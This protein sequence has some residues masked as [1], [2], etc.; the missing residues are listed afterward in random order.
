V[1]EAID[2]GASA[3]AEATREHMSLLVAK[4]DRLEVAIAEAFDAILP[5][6]ERGHWTPGEALAW[7]E[8]A[9]RLRISGASHRCAGAL[10]VSTNTLLEWGKALPGSP[11]SLTGRFPVLHQPTPARGVPCVY[12]LL[13]TDSACLYIGTSLYVRRR[14]KVHWQG[15][16]I[17]ATSWQVIVAGSPAEAL[18]LEGDLIFQHQPPYNEQGRSARRR[19]RVT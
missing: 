5:A 4:R 7:W 11:S 10:G 17:P 16:R 18:Q 3:S 6:I 2:H 15:G 14:L 19:T 9:R 1:S 13:D 12:L 8:W